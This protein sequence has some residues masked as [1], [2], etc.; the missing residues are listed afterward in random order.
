ME[1]PRVT[2]GALLEVDRE[3]IS[4]LIV[5]GGGRGIIARREVDG[6]APRPRDDYDRAKDHA[7]ASSNAR[8]FSGRPVR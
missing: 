5:R 7:R 1:I 4:R 8:T 6:N 3:R 2:R